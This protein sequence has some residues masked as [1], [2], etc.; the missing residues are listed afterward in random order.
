LFTIDVRGH[1]AAKC[2]YGADVKP[3]IG[4]ALGG[5]FAR[6]I[7]H[8]GVLRVFE[9]YR[10]P[11]RYI[12]GVSA[13]AVAAAAFASGS[14]S[15]EIQGICRSLRFSDVAGWCISKLALAKTERMVPFLRKLLKT[16]RFEEMRIPLCVVATNLANGEP[17]VFHA[18]GDVIP[19]VRASCCYPG[20][21]HP[22][23]HKDMLL[24]DG[25]ISMGIPALPLKCMGATHVIS[26]HLQTQDCASAAQNLFQVVNR[27]MQILQEK[28][29][30]HWQKY[31]ELVIKPYVNDIAWNGFESA[32]KLID[33]GEEAAEAALPQIRALIG[34]AFPPIL[35]RLDPE[36][37]GSEGS[38]LTSALGSSRSAESE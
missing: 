21:L 6:G 11:I 28:S 31:S 29:A 13:G 1:S 36:R 23:H 9:R 22:V 15:E 20:L 10:I 18:H 27:C 17:V 34:G 3:L 4:L 2:D 37:P 24:V 38:R 12:G 30:G 25:A 33:A 7:A 26:V 32:E 5:G 16:F 14:C 19:A 35:D 8:V